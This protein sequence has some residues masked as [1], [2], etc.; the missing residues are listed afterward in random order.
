MSHIFGENQVLAD[1]PAKPAKVQYEYD[2][3]QNFRF[4]DHHAEVVAQK[5]RM[6]E[7]EMTEMNLLDDEWEDIGDTESVLSTT[8]APQPQEQDED[9]EMSGLEKV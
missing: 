4:F 3:S 1:A 2:N 7:M 8:S 9:G 6:E 5:K